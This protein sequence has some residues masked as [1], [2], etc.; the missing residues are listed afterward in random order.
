[1]VK[2]TALIITYNEIIHI[3]GLIENLS[4]ANEIIF[5]DS[6][7]TD[8][9]FEKLNKIEKVKVYQHEFENFAKQKNYALSLSSNDW[10][11]FIDADERIT[12]EYKN[13]IIKKINSH[14]NYVAYNSLFRYYFGKIP[15]KYSGFQTTK[16]YR[17]IRVS[18]CFYDESRTVHERLI[19]NGDSGLLK[20]RII[21]YSFRNYEHYKEKMKLY[22]HLKAK[23]LHK[24]GKKVTFFKSKI[25][26]IYRFFN[27]YIIRLGILDGMVGFY[28][29]KLNAYEV[30]ERYRE[31]DRLNKKSFSK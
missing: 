25:K 17:L 10:V 29:S 3:D 20:Y 23:K 30:I 6:F 5:V 12:N 31:L 18:K 8:G 26:P 14:N 9:T 11:L 21:H 22:A 7:S 16:S 15:I 2:L 19:V 28:I 4:F 24:E 27:H 1:M 13:D